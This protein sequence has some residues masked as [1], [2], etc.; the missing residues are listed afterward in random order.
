VL[1]PF[2]RF[3]LVSNNLN[4]REP[5][6]KR[7]VI[8][9]LE[10]GAGLAG[11]LVAGW[12]QGNLWANVFTVN[13]MTGT[14]VG[15]VVMLCILAWT[16]SASALPWTWRWH[17]FWYM[18][19]TL[20]NS[21]L[22]RWETTFAPLEMAERSH[23]LFRTEVI[24]NGERKDLIAVLHDSVAHS[25]NR[26]RRLLL[27]GEPGAGKTTAME[28]LTLTLARE[29]AW[30]LGFNSPLP[31][32]V[33]LGDFQEGPFID[34]LRQAIHHGTRRGSG[35]VLA[36]GLESLLAKGHLALFIDA[37]DE[38]LGERHEQV[39]AQIGSFLR[40]QSYQRVP[41]IITCR[42]REDPGGRLNDLEVF[43][44]QNLKDD[45][46]KKMIQSYG[47]LAQQG[48]DVERKLREVGLLDTQGIGRNPFWL[49]LIL[50][51][52]VFFGNKGKILNK[53]VESLLG[54]EWDKPKSKRSWEK[55]LPKDEQLNETIRGLAWLAYKM[56]IRSQVSLDMNDALSELRQW[57]G[58]RVGTQD[59][60]AQ[61]ILALG[62]D[63]L[64]LNYEIGISSSQIQPLR[65]RH[66]LLQE[67]LTAWCLYSQKELLTQGLIEQFIADIG[68]KE[69]FLM[70]GGL[71]PDHKPLVMCILGTHPNI[72][73]LILAVGLLQSINKLN[74]DMAQELT[75]SLA[76]CL[77]SDF[78]AKN[79]KAVAEITRAAPFVFTPIL[80][81][82]LHRFDQEVK[83]KTIEV[84]AEIRNQGAAEVLVRSL[85]DVR[86]SDQA[87][88]ALICIGEPAI[89]PL[90]GAL[91]GRY[92]VSYYEDFMIFEWVWL[93]QLKAANALAQIGKSAVTAL[94]KAFEIDNSCDIA[95]VLG[96]IKDERAVNPLVKVLLNNKTLSEK[97]VCAAEALGNLEDY[98]SVDALLEGLTHKDWQVRRSVTNALAKINDER[99][100]AP[101]L[102]TLNDNYSAVKKSAALAIGKLGDKNVVGPLLAALRSPL[103]NADVRQSI[104]DALCKLGHHAV[105]PLA[106]VICNSNSSLQVYAIEVLGKISDS[107][108][109]SAL[110]P[111]LQTNNRSVLLCTVKA[112]EGIGDI[113]A[114]PYLKS[115]LENAR[116]NGC[117]DSEV[118]NVVT[119]TIEKMDRLDK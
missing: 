118:I 39:L 43:E 29:G 117:E 114:L 71:E 17:K 41:M 116:Q 80:L 78:T 97:K 22:R 82:L 86:I 89:E 24:I 15:A 6:I 65:F 62:R 11:N 70:L 61:D 111:L 108:S 102:E 38:A 56:S 14:A 72:H 28:H 7:L 53:A 66:R 52:G 69:T 98:R 44:I 59:L 100:V 40:S 1:Y 119:R 36:S 49:G 95:K 32:L 5:V 3:S 13:R 58:G 76:E 68:W 30:R 60:R 101:L 48:L 109:T 112:L 31:I 67:F 103:N 55:R 73:R 35:R 50:R 91:L 12:I 87:Y 25:A 105:E 79:K 16:E 81:L 63:A 83:L 37:L 54:R 104:V 45:S 84:L 57:S 92:Q 19:E 77:R 94:L 20:E 27:L 88:D 47:I 110:I 2:I 115:F 64:L 42:T 8:L 107:R 93:I 90:I 10:F 26:A 85:G 4:R 18:L 9:F 106:S 99:A 51:S 74:E 113:S 96:K 23:E 75:L 34:H 46:V 33:R 21:A